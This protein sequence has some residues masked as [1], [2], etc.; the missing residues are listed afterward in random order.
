MGKV[1]QMPTPQWDEI[2]SHVETAND[3]LAW[4][5]RQVL[6]Q[7]EYELARRIREQWN[8]MTDLLADVR[9]QR[10]VR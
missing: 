9:R 2:E 5:H 10:G 8:A 7:Q 4:A 6:G 3:A 1:L